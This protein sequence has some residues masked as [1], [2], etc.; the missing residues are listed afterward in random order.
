MDHIKDI[1]DD[2]VLEI[3][4][5]K[6]QNSNLSKLITTFTRENAP[7]YP[8]VKR[9]I[10]ENLNKKKGSISTFL[11]NFKPGNSA[12]TAGINPQYLID[13]HPEGR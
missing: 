4:S 10:K 13:S 3:A 5:N 11:I 9:G 2:P 7:I 12:L 6:E 8:K 1:I